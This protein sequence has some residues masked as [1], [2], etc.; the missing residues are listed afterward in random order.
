MKNYRKLV[1]YGIIMF[2]TLL[3][4]GK[5]LAE[6]VVLHPEWSAEF[7][8]ETTTSAQNIVPVV[9]EKETTKKVVEK[10]TLKKVGGLKKKTTYKYYKGYKS[11]SSKKMS[12]IRYKYGIQFTWKKV[13]KATGYQVYRYRPAAKKWEKIATT[14]K[15]SYTLTNMLKGEN[16]IIKVRAYKK[17]GKQYEY[18]KWS[19]TIKFKTKEPY[20]KIG[21]NYKLKTFYDKYASEDAF[22]IQNEERK[23]AGVSLIR[24]DEILY[25]ICKVR[26]KEISEGDFSHKK[27]RETADTIFTYRYKIDKEYVYKPTVD[28]SISVVFTNDISENISY[29]RGTGSQAILGWKNSKGHYL[30]MTNKGYISGAIA[31]YKE[32]WVAIFSKYNMD[33]I[34]VGDFSSITSN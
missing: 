33:E 28:S 4:S 7:N 11:A 22:V 25:D 17:K 14:K 29:G 10:I 20:Q 19:Q 15:T 27:F 12:K 23:S 24:W 2:V 6:E 9:K 5:V 30:N 13:K 16:V 3:M 31:Y 26:V 1:I 32:Y 18:G 34:A 21:P 8:G